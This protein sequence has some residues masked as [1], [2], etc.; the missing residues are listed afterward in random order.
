MDNNQKILNNNINNLCAISQI[1]NTRKTLKNL[2][3]ENEIPWVSKCKKRQKKIKTPDKLISRVTSNLLNL[4]AN[5]SDN[6]P[7]FSEINKQIVKANQLIGEIPEEN[8]EII[9]SLKNLI[10]VYSKYR[11]D[12]VKKIE[13]FKKSLNDNEDNNNN[14]NFNDEDLDYFFQ[15][16]VKILK[17]DL[18][19]REILLTLAFKIASFCT[20]KNEFVKNN[21]Y[22][23]SCGSI[24][25][26]VYFKVDNG[27]GFLCPVR[28][29][30]VYTFYKIFFNSETYIS[31]TQM[32][33]LKKMPITVAEIKGRLN[34]K[35]LKFQNRILPNVIQMEPK[36]LEMM[37][38]MCKCTQISIQASHLIS[39]IPFNDFLEQQKDNTSNL[40]SF[41][42]IK[43]FSIHFISSLLLLPND[44][45]P[46]NFILQDNKTLVGIDNDCSILNDEFQK[47]KD[48]YYV[49]SKNIFYTLPLMDE[50]IDNSIID[51]FKEM[52]IELFILEW[53]GKSNQKEILIGKM[54]REIINSSDIEM[55]KNT[56]SL[57][58]A[59]PDGWITKFINRFTKIKEEF[60]SFDTPV[61]HRQLFKKISPFLSLYY[62][63]LA[64]WAAKIPVEKRLEDYKSDFNYQ[65]FLL[66]VEKLPFIQMCDEHSGL[67]QKDLLPIYENLKKS[68][69]LY[70]I[71]N[72]LLFQYQKHQYST[73]EELITF[74]LRSTVYSKE[75]FNIERLSRFFKIINNLTMNE[76]N[77]TIKLSS[78]NFHSTWEHNKY[79]ILLRLIKNGESETTIENTIKIFEIDLNIELSKKKESTFHCVIRSKQSNEIKIKQLE[80][81]KRYG[82]DIEVIN[83]HGSNTT[84]LDYAA[85]EENNQLFVWFIKNG[86]GSKSMDLKT[87]ASFYY[88]LLYSEKKEL[89]PYMN[90]LYHINQK[91]A[92]KFATKSLLPV[93][94]ESKTE[95]KTNTKSNSKIV[96][97]F[98]K[99]RILKEEYI[100]QIFETDG[101]ILIPKKNNLGKS[102]VPFIEDFG[103]R[104]YFKFYPIYPGNEKSVFILSDLL[105]GLC[106]PF[107][108][109][110][111]IEKIFP[112]LLIQHV[113]GEELIYKL[114][115]E[116]SPI[117]NTIH[118]NEF[119]IESIDE[120]DLIQKPIELDQIQEKNLS[121][122]LILAMLI[123]DADGNFG[124][125]IISKVSPN[126]YRI[127]SID[128]ELAFAPPIITNGKPIKSIG[129]SNALLVLD[130]MFKKVDI[131]TIEELKS[132]NIEEIIQK[133]LKK[134]E[135]KHNQSTKLF[136]KINDLISAST[137]V[138]IPM[139][140]NLIYKI[141]TKLLRLKKDLTNEMT[142]F[143]VFI[144]L[145]PELAIRVKPILY[146]PSLS[147]FKRYTTLKELKLKS[148]TS[149]ISGNTN[150]IN[151]LL[152]TSIIPYY[153]DIIKMGNFKPNNAI[154]EFNRIMEQVNQLNNI[155]SNQPLNTTFLP[156]AI[157]MVL[158]DLNFGALTKQ[159]EINFFNFIKKNILNVCSVYIKGSK[160]FSSNH[161]DRL[162]SPTPITRINITNSP[163]FEGF[164]DKVFVSLTHL[165]VEGCSNL[166]KI[167]IKAKNLIYLNA[168]RCPLIEEII[169]GTPH[170]ECLLL[171]DTI[172]NK[173]YLLLDIVSKYK[174]LKLLDIGFS[175][176]TQI[177]SLELYFILPDLKQFLANNLIG[178]E[179]LIIYMPQVK[180]FEANLSTANFIFDGKAYYDNNK[181]TQLAESKKRRIL[182][183]IFGSNNSFSHYFLNYF[184]HNVKSLGIGCILSLNFRSSLSM[185]FTE[186][187]KDFYFQTL[188]CNSFI[189]VILE[190]DNDDSR[191]LINENLKCYFGNNKKFTNHIKFILITIGEEKTNQSK[192]KSLKKNLDFSFE[193]NIPTVKVSTPV[194]K[195]LRKSETS[196]KTNYIDPD[197]IYSWTKDLVLLNN[198][199]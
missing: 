87:C 193:I 178:I 126:Q 145:E 93:N 186:K 48:N 4:L 182:I 53:L 64:K 121:K 116:S 40:S 8:N 96:K 187:K 113:P 171:K 85:M 24:I 153:M 109:V 16:V 18:L 163:T 67:E 73:I 55:Y 118:S 5:M 183:N 137:I 112:V 160:I 191:K 123:N 89:E 157:E 151:L 115:K 25:N 29:N 190:L 103:L 22:G 177:D 140:E 108:K 147:P 185:C 189:F 46:D 27:S 50:F 75:N 134:L 120:K 152:E 43:S 138:G 81:L 65:M 143:D 10:T 146:N 68:E 61:T 3:L 180:K 107:S 188:F 148:K 175:K 91:L 28:E 88:G 150:P 56:L 195:V 196:K 154:A 95:T 38:F 11:E 168:S 86:S 165:Y 149:Q 70:P 54:L 159:E 174:N 78:E 114:I 1:Q 90:S 162:F 158:Y 9:E 98:K 198:L 161:F 52:D 125:F 62:E 197:Q 130:L 100:N 133:W 94:E 80:V 30:A 144:L 42:D 167:R 170:L 33:F 192:I 59:I 179:K 117:R 110:V 19:P 139:Y 57:P 63:S 69:F 12:I 76:T 17:E 41:I 47:T 101:N 104:I 7:L 14:F 131:S 26:S 102:A 199:S 97:T 2:N 83:E 39:G 34:K 6:N 156:A 172:T 58:T 105:F 122:Q 45:K 135:K 124:N 49:K 32:I 44:S 51:I 82:A 71:E 20:K 136:Y 128:N 99:T 129:S 72:K 35:D 142:Y 169:L 127:V 66:Y 141:H 176:E 173:N 36:L 79:L 23:I 194:R 119:S 15:P 77:L 60:N 166:T 74:Q 106:T 84:P 21:K 13:N 181:Y 111:V 37:D 92:W 132:I 155:K 184:E 164:L 31:P